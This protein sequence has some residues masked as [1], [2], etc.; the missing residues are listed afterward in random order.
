MSP[1]LRN[2]PSPGQPVHVGTAIGRAFCLGTSCATVSIEV[3]AMLAAKINRVMVEIM[4]DKA[5]MTSLSIPPLLRCG[6]GELGEWPI[7][8]L[9]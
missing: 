4:A 8:I 9:T 2:P 5:G 6:L 1:E 7:D 3:N